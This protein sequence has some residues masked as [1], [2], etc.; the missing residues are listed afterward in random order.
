LTRAYVCLTENLSDPPRLPQVARIAGISETK[1]KR[2]FKKQY[3]LTPRGL[4]RA[5]RM[6]A[7]HEM[8]RLRGHSVSEAAYAV[9]YCNVSHFIDAFARHYGFKPGR[10]RARSGED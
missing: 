7:A 10:L 6:A 8:M 4:V 3:G 1:L 9:G 2:L 5:Q